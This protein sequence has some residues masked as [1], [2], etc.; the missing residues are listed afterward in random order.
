L[1]YDIEYD[2]GSDMNDVNNSFEQRDEDDEGYDDD[3]P[4]D[5]N[6]YEDEPNDEEEARMIRVDND[7]EDEDES[8]R[9]WYN[10][11]G[12]SKVKR[13][14][15]KFMNELS[16]HGIVCVIC[17]EKKPSKQY[18]WLSDEKLKQWY[19]IDDINELEKWLYP[20]YPSRELVKKVCN[21]L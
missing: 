15:K 17:G 8:E 9:W 13:Y 5:V 12:W 20:A 6:S 16:D 7:D 4:S 18:G 19:R 1:D 14:G 11:E 10:D 2:E 21:C 3:T